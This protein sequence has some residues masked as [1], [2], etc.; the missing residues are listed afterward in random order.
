M[1][2][3]I[4]LLCWPLLTIGLA[5]QPGCDRVE[6]PATGEMEYTTLSPA[7]ERQIGEEQHPLILQQF[8]GEYP[9]P[10]L[11]AY[12]D[13]VG[14]QLA[15]ASDLPEAEFTF[16]LLDSEVANAFALP[17]GY[18]YLT[19]GLLALAENEA[20]MAGVLGHEIGHVTARHSAQRQTR[21]TGAGLVATLGTIGAAILGGEMAGRLAQQVTGVGA[22]AY[23]AGYSRDQELEA[24][25][26]GIR[27]LARA[28]YD[29]RA[30]ASFLEKLNAESDLQR[31]LA[32]DEG[33]GAAMSWFATHPRTLDRVKQAVEEIGES[34]EGRIGRDQYLARID[35]LVYGENPSQ[36]LV[37]GS[38]FVHPDLG[39]AFEAPSGFRL[40]NTPQ[41]V[42]GRDRQN[43][44]MLFTLADPDGRSLE[45]YV[46]G[47]G[48]Q[49]VARLAQAEVSRPRGV[50]TFRVDGRPAAS[51]SATLRKGDTLADVG[52]A[53]IDAG[54][55]TYQ[56]IFLSP[57]QMSRDEARAYRSTVESFRRLD[58]AEAARFEAKR[59]RVVPV[60]SGQS[61]QELADRMAVEAAPRE[62]FAILNALALN[63]GLRS[64][65]QVKL[66]VD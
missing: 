53:A 10:E 32:G 46:A 45:E 61:A 40:A 6:N 44:Q 49:Q 14:E 43:R 26:L 52:L 24:D 23:L 28:G 65:E 55:S 1:T 59:I 54:D 66:V 7:Q 29:A 19:R 4:R 63:D 18:V 42:I 50:Q 13:E 31:Q 39:F 2:R 9:D 57:G 25:Q 5:L 64:G 17:G 34:A 30:M 38:R 62:Q 41:A 22:Q 35:G 36:G 20:E 58:E 60:E 56:F 47:P 33:E 15:A 37:R 8:G 16:T 11:Q 48:L 27:Y 21:A 3:W 51:A 12:V